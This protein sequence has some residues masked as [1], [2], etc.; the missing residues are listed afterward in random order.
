MRDT[1]DAGSAP[2]TGIAG[3]SPLLA[4]RHRARVGFLEVLLIAGLA[5]LLNAL[6]DLRVDDTC[7][8]YYANHH[9]QDPL[10][11][12]GWEIIW[13]QSPDSA[14]NPIAPPVFVYWWSLAIRLFG[15]DQ[16]AW[17]LW[18]FPIVL[19]LVLSTRDLL[20]RFAPRVERPLL[21]FLIFSP[22]ILPSLN[23]MLAVPCLAFTS[24]SLALFLRGADRRSIG[25]TLLS[26]VFLGLAM[27]TKWP[28]FLM[29]AVLF[30]AAFFLGRLRDWALA[31]AVGAAM[32]VGF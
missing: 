25:L 1:S 16:F 21:W 22:F 10:D 31:V 15:Q 20:R 28:A 19:A 24:T 29:I 30:C 3:P 7:L 23:L 11:P 17:K 8:Y 18:L 2:A 4:A 32:F 26:G 6:K 9:A 27:M 5:T 12:Y 14:Q 13:G